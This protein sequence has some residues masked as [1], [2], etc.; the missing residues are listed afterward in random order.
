[1]KQN[2]KNDSKNTI[3]RIKKMGVLWN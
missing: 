1:V 2:Y 3:L